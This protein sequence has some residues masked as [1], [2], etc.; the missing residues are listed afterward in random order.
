M[1]A[2]SQIRVTANVNFPRKDTD[3]PSTPRIGRVNT[4]QVLSIGEDV[5]KERAE[6]LLSKKYAVRLSSKGDVDS[7]GNPVGAES[8]VAVQRATRAASEQ[9]EKPADQGTAQEGQP[10]SE[11]ADETA[12]RKGKGKK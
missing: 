2:K 8:D 11:D 3:A 12:A 6:W 7:E 4:G 1:A 10:Q 9:H 5:S